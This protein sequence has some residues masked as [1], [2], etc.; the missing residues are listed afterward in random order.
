VGGVG[1]GLGEVALA[2][3]GPTI[4]RFSALPIHSRVARRV[5]LVRDHDLAGLPLGGQ[6]IDDRAQVA[7]GEPADDRRQT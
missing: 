6:V 3:A 1:D 5:R 4:T 7:A 2:G